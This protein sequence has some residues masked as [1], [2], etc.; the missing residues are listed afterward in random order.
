MRFVD[1]QEAGKELAMALARYRG[2]DTV[3]YALP[4][5]GVVLGFEV[6]RA[7]HASLDL[8]IARK[9]GHPHSPEYAVCAVTEKNG[10][11][12]NENERAK[13][14]PEWLDRAVQRERQEAARR[15][16]VYLKN[17][18]HI[19]PRDKTAIIVDDGIATGLSI[20]AALQ[21]V[22]AQKPRELVVAVPVA[23]HEIA[24]MLR[25]EADTVVILEESENYLGAVGAYYE[26][27]P[28]VSD[29]QVIELLKRSRHKIKS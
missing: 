5:G 29:M 24:E 14:D 26:Y 12:C 27:F 21:S 6:A 10:L 22:R 28:Q 15:R 16:K 20:L 13:L 23:P 19:S 18:E 3:V 9:I 7:L 4:R 8:V 1:R 2:R 11:V 17:V 25:S